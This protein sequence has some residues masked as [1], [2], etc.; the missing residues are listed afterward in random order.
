MCV[1]QMVPNIFQR[2]PLTCY[3]ALAFA[4][5]WGA[6]FLLIGPNGFPASPESA[7]SYLPFVVVA[8]LLGPSVAGIVTTFIVQGR[9]GLQ[10]LWSKLFKWRIWYGFIPLFIPVTI[11]SILAILSMVVSPEWYTPAIFRADEKL[12]GGNKIG[13]VTIGLCYGVAAGIFEEIGWSGF[14]VQELMRRGSDSFSAGISVG[15]I[16]GIWHFFVAF[17]GSGGPNGKFSTDLF[18]PWVPWNLLVLPAFRVIMVHIFDQTGSILLMA[19]IHGSLT[20]SLPLILMPSV[21][22]IPLASFYTLLAFAFAVI[23]KVFVV[24]LI[25]GLKEDKRAKVT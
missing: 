4:I 1:Q 5:S 8:T 17:W 10:C 2:Q 20:A 7:D 12:L 22:G 24:R 19:A 25:R 11:G 23:Y 16:W 3:Y 18:V 14:A 15:L 9:S 21:T 6:V 13:F